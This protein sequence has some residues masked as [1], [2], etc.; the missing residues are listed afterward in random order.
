MKCN[1]SYYSWP[2][3]SIVEPNQYLVPNIALFG[4][5]FRIRQKKVKIISSK[6]IVNFVGEHNSF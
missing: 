4:I 5:L 1:I 2:I 3:S 6:P